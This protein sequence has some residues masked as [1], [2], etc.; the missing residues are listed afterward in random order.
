MN[1][2]PSVDRVNHACIPLIPLPI[3]VLPKKITS[4]NKLLAT[5]RTLL[6]RCGV[7]GFGR[8]SYSSEEKP[9]I[10]GI[11]FQRLV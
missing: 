7:L 9:C 5:G 4:K 8:Y 2:L 10:K 11:C 1:S 3:A 6:P